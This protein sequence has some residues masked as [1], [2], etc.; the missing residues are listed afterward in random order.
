MCTELATNSWTSFLLSSNRLQESLRYERE[1]VKVTANLL[2][3]AVFA[4]PVI[5]QTNPA[6][7]T[8]HQYRQQHEHR[9][10][11][12]FVSLLA[13]PDVASDHANI[14]RNAEAIAEMMKKRGLEPKLVSVEGA[15][16][17]VFGE[18]RTLGA[19]A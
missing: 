1:F 3:M 12:E 10:M 8:A 17:V 4:A 7:I 18:I 6:A 16:P 9:I 13:I 2:L 15:N 19:T 5:A 11:D 14:Q